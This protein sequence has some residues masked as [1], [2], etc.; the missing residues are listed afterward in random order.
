[1]IRVFLGRFGI[2]LFATAFAFALLTSA[3]QQTQTAPQAATTLRAYAVSREVSVQGTVVS[4]TE[5][6]SVPPLGARVSIQTTS[7]VLDVHLGNPA[8]LQAHK[9]TIA[10]GDTVRVIGENLSYGSGTQFFARIIQ[11]GSQ[12]VALRSTRGF[13]LRPAAKAGKTQAGVL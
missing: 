5:N 13:P 1:M 6:S 9:L 10:S 2:S 3:Q 7:G 11:K 4:F 8:L 12:A